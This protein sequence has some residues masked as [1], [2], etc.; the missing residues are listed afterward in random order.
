MKL[1]VLVFFALSAFG[2]QYEMDRYVMGLLKKGPNWSN[3][4]TPETAKLQEGHMA[5]IKKMADT[6][7]LI[8]AG[9][10][11]GNNE[12]YRG[13]FIFKATM[14]EA[15]GMADEDPA[16]KAGQLALELYPW[17]AAKGLSIAPPK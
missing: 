13:V 4:K 7:K 9:P 1:L 3:A 10:F 2:Q 8:V 16:I 12:T 15:K 14:E 11:T 6:G 5:N 17:Y